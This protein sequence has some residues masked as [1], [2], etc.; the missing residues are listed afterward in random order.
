MPGVMLD[1]S[2]KYVKFK[3]SPLRLWVSGHISC[4]LDIELT[5]QEQYFYGV[6]GVINKA[7]VNK[8][9]SIYS[10]TTSDIINGD[11]LEQ[12]RFEKPSNSAPINFGIKK[13][14]EVKSLIE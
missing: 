9:R 13:F 12:L 8:T 2:T 11:L 7:A 3:S 5:E 14:M 1:R 6:E 10:S 4:Q